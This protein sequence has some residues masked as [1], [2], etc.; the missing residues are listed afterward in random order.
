MPDHSDPVDQAGSPGSSRNKE[1]REAIDNSNGNADTPP[2]NQ[3]PDLAGL[4]LVQ[5]PLEVFW[6][7]PSG[8][9]LQ[10]NE[11]AIRNL[12]YTREEINGLFVGEIDQYF[13]Q[14]R[15]PQLF[16]TLSEKK[17]LNV[18]SIRKRR[19]G[20]IYPVETIVSH[21][22]ADGREYLF[23]IA[24]PLLGPG[25][26]MDS[27]DRIRAFTQNGGV[28]AGPTTGDMDSD[29][30]ASQETEEEFQIVSALFEAIVDHL[31]DIIMIVRADHRV[32]MLNRAGCEAFGLPPGAIAGKFCYN[33]LGKKKPCPGCILERTQKSGITETT[34]YSIPSLGKQYLLH[35]IPVRDQDGNIIFVILQYSDI[36][37]RVPN[38]R[39]AREANEKLRL[40]SNITAHDVFNQLSVLL[41]YLNLIRRANEKQE[42]AELIDQVEAA[43]CTI[44][45]QL[46][47]M[48]DYQK[49]GSV[50]P[51]WQ[52]I[53][54]VMKGIWTEL[55]TKDLALSLETDGLEVYADPLLKKIFYN[56]VDNTLKH[57]KNATR[58]RISCQRANNAICM[59][60]ENNGAGIP[61]EMKERIFQKGYGDHSGYGLYLV[62]K[63]LAVTG[64]DIREA[65]EA[66]SGVR[67]EIRV[68]DGYWR[69]SD[70]D[71]S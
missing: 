17:A 38:E 60:Y 40:L 26:H 54:E 7:V 32:L 29:I 46:E 47:C 69:R 33:L 67:F 1:S 10:A 25:M 57:G 23:C 30:P 28:A 9:I 13:T 65:G 62:R 49:I 6:I 3:T 18:P 58:V 63:I 11:S 52:R 24:R 43:A 42:I 50:L 14:D 34:E 53:D 61:E 68:P 31:P 48:K 20:S 39:S 22:I 36:G 64:F 16:H 19:D 2:V 12:G 55:P 21:L 27:T 71:L 41:G 59:V 37:E 51:S 56:L 44:R 45:S 5:N 66:G 4:S 70:A 15:L 35:G 8:K